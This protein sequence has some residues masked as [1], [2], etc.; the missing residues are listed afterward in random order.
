MSIWDRAI[1]RAHFLLK[2]LE[3]KS[4]KRLV[5][6]LQPPHDFVSH[7]TNALSEDIGDGDITAALIPI[8]ETANAQIITR[9]T[10]IIAGRPWVDEVFRQLDLRN[11]SEKNNIQA[12]HIEWHCQEGDHVEA[13]HVLFTL[14]GNA[15]TLLTGE[16]TALNFLQLLS[17]TA[18]RSHHYQRLV[19]HTQVKLLDTRKTIPGLRTAQKYAVRCGGCH[20]HRIGLFD[21]YLIK[22]NHIAA[23][24][25]ISNAI[26][27]AK[28]QASKLVEVEVENFDEFE[29]ALEANKQMSLFTDAKK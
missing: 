17:A 11:Q 4:L 3:M 29:Q 1:H 6:T 19:A 27:T 18:T 7:V 16:R 13:N 5:M 28:Q 10:C 2:F 23:C 15:R 25:S 9:Q 20:N 21:A 26:A 12:T 22:E 14:H 24:G 8:H